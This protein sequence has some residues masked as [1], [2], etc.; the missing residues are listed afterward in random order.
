M[1]RA[2]LL[3]ASVFAVGA[4]VAAALHASP[5][6]LGWCAAIACL[7]ITL[8]AAGAARELHAPDDLR[9]PRHDRGPSRVEPL[10]ADMVSRSGSF[11]RL[12]GIAIGAFAVLG[13]APF[14]ALARRP[15]PQGT[16]W[17]AGARV[18]T[19]DGVALRADALA[20]GGVATVFP[21]GHVGAPESATLLVRL[22]P[23]VMHAQPGRE[24]WTPSDNVAYSK[25]CTHAGCPVALYRRASQQLYCP[26][27]QSVF[28][29]LDGARPVSGPATRA[30][31]QLALDIDADGY[32]IARGDFSAP[33]GPDEWTR[34]I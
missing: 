28:D 9:E 2:G 17:S 22:P 30:L 21:A 7:G 24:G 18:V 34:R 32:L 27:H 12:W 19:P 10:P 25:I 5:A 33:V 11:G 23:G 14:I 29:V 20:E 26:C 31:P 4:T 15:A 8:A 16:A 6:V 3:I 1:T 13:V